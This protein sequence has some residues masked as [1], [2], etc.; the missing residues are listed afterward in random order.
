M[1]QKKGLHWNVY[2]EMMALTNSQKNKVRSGRFVEIYGGKWFIFSEI[3]RFLVEVFSQQIDWVI[4]D[5]V[6]HFQQTFVKSRDYELHQIVSKGH[7]LYLLLSFCTNY[8]DYLVSKLISCICDTFYLCL[9]FL[10]LF[11]PA[12]QTVFIL[13]LCKF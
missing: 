6:R 2:Y 4:R 10:F 7:L 12:F 9:L 11:L 3:I 1:L 13:L 8:F 5:N